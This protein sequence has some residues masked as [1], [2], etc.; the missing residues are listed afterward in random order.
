VNDAQVRQTVWGQLQLAE[1]KRPFPEKDRPFLCTSEKAS[2][3]GK[4]CVGGGHL[5]AQKAAQ[6][7][8]PPSTLC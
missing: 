1:E 3:K 4:H 2:K 7:V 6:L 8:A 5:G